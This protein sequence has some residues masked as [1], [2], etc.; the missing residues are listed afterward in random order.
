L[1]AGGESSIEQLSQ[2]TTTTTTTTKAVAVARTL[3]ANLTLLAN[4]GY[5][6]FNETLSAATGGIA[7]RGRSLVKFY[8]RNGATALRSSMQRPQIGRI[9]DRH[10][11]PTH[12]HM[13]A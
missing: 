12:S 8:L 10:T 6:R 3:I 13:S 4:S 5:D 1:Y 2:T 9:N 11:K 7:T